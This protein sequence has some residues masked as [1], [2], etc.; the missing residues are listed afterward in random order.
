MILLYYALE[1]LKWLII[2]RA[3]LSWFVPPHSQNPIVQVIRR[4]TDPILQPFQ[5][6]LPQMGGMDVSPLVAFFAIYLLQSLI[7]G[8]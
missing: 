7:V 8:L 6:V 4:I 1:L 3:L 5:S 2:A